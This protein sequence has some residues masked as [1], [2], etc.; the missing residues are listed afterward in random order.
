MNINP[1][2][3]GSPVPPGIFAGRVKEIELI[4]RAVVQ[5]SH[6]SPQNML[7]V[8]ERGIGKTSVAI[9]SKAIALKKIP[10]LQEFKNPLITAYFTVRKNTHPAIVITQLIEELEQVLEPHTT[11]LSIV[12]KYI[13]A[14]TKRFK[15]ISV[16]GISLETHSEKNLTSDDIYSE[17][18][19]TLRKIAAACFN[20]NN[21]EGRA[22]CLIIDE[23]DQMSD[24]ENF[25]SFWKTLQEL[26]LADDVNNLMLIFVG[27]PEMVTSL[28]NDHES[29]LR[30]FTPIQL[31][32]MN[33][34]DARNVVDKALSNTDKSISTDALNKILYY[35]ERYPHLI[36]EIG[37]TAFEVSKEKE[38]S[39]S[40]VEEGVHGKQDFKGSIE[41]LGEL[42]FSKMYDEVKK[43]DN[44]KQ[45]LKIVANKSGLNQDW[46]PRQA[47]LDNFTLKKTSCDSAIRTLKDKNILVKNPNK[48]GEYRLFS[49]MFQVY[50][51]KML[52]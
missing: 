22:I 17:A 28:N 50:I 29:F 47:I 31:D 20:Q 41:R 23:L 18:R 38:I 42:F 11:I 44:F 49:K 12:G 15:G 30:T 40:D 46:V 13:E 51:S 19:K 48:D 24:G 25:S 10:T 14:F 43:S 39:L 52:N 34:E 36:Q 2:K 21:G 32:K 16:K 37:Y 1:F 7:I 9:L 27:M 26:L 6:F 33:E 3:P 45:I 8:G 4:Y 5:T 35:S